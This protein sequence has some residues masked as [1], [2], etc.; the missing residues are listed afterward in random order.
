VEHGSSG[1]ILRAA[2]GLAPDDIARR[3]KDRYKRLRETAVATPA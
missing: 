1:E 3:V 2:Y